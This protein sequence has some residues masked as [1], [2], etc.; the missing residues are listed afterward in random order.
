MTSSSVATFSVSEQKK[1]IS[2]AALVAGFARSLHRV[3][4]SV[5]VLLVEDYPRF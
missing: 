5:I 3:M 4:I 1:R 2:P